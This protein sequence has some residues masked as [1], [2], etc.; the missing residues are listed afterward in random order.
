MGTVYEAVDRVIERTVAIKTIRK[1]DLDPEDAA[2]YARRFLT[3]A[4][5]AGKLNHP[6]IVGLYDYGEADG[7]AYI[8]MELVQGRELQHW[9]DALHPFT[10]ADTLR[11]MGQLLDALGY[12]HQRGVV[13]RDVKPANIF[14][15]D[16]GVLKLGD[17]GIARIESSQRTRVG[18]V[19]G[20]PTHMAPEQV[21]GERADARSDLYAAGVVLFQFLTGVR[22]FQGTMLAVAMKVVSEPP[23]RASSL[24]P[25]VGPAMDAVVARALAKDPA[26]RY[27]S[28]AEFWQALLE[29]SGLGAP[30][31]PAETTGRF[32]P[33]AFAP[34]GFAPGGYSP[35]VFGA[36]PFGEGTGLRGSS[37]GT[38]VRGTG[39]GTG[40]RETGPASGAPSGPAAG[41]V[42]VPPPALPPPPPPSVPVPPPPQ[43]L[44]AP[45]AP[46]YEAPGV[47]VPAPPPAAR[48]AAGVRPATQPP[49]P[50]A[51]PGADHGA[52]RRAAAPVPAA[53]AAAPAGR[54]ATGA[55]P[56]PSPTHPPEART[57][58]PA[59]RAGPSPDAGKQ[60]AVAPAA[61]ARRPLLAAAGLALAAAVAAG[62]GL[63]W[64]RRRAG[65]ADP[66][67]APPPAGPAPAASAPAS[68]AARG[69]DGT[70]TGAPDPGGAGAAASAPP[71]AP[72]G[73]APAPAPARTAP[74][75]RR[76]APPRRAEAPAP[77]PAAERREP[78][79]RPGGHNGL[80]PRCSDILQKAS[81][82]P[83]SP[84]ETAYLK[85]ECQ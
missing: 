73:P 2:E 32:G 14:V 17:F 7:L 6:H 69:D 4:R 75:E 1:A 35:S 20:T 13:H 71:P 60:A 5:A 44:P 79:V 50:A 74:P 62:G 59:G 10:P 51:P 70:Q 19:L 21:R 45:A 41:P 54:T 65:G 18:A 38:G 56:P 22:P 30:A 76:P 58:A 61:P 3:E 43:P 85:R 31:G 9:F 81:L 33:S 64:M 47:T 26:E 68:S 53:A 8:V 84:E 12:S 34:S 27:Q 23:P 39:P 37:P 55:L 66:V 36:G 48:T 77:A 25:D 52:G 15:T 80:P 82:E 46:D 63:L 16:E 67:A 42:P 40:W 78:A 83:L 49:G 29:A 24:R 72:A 57:R 11:L 28:A